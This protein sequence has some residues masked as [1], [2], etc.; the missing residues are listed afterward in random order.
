MYDKQTLRKQLPRVG[1]TRM[2]VP[3]VCKILGCVCAP[4]PQKCVVTHV[5]TRNLWYRVR[6]IKTGTAQ[7][8]KLPMV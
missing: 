5:H 6:F 3:A 4:P 1:D 8:Y 2:E 7:C